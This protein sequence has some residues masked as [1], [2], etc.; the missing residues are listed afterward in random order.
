MWQGEVFA[1]SDCLVG[2]VINGCVCYLPPDNTT[3]RVDP[4]EFYDN[5]VSQIYMYQNQGTFFLC[6]DFNYR[7]GNDCDF[8]EGV[9]PVE[10]RQVVDFNKNVYGD[11]LLEFL[12]NINCVM[13][14]GRNM[15][16]DDANDYTSVSHRGLAVVD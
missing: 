4:H 7:C 6:G 9:D 8:I 15:K 13:V 3:R 2:T 1:I 10:E 11:I 16:S 12:I 14:N 5:L